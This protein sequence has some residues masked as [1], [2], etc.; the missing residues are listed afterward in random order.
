MQ[1]RDRLIDTEENDSYGEV[2]DGRIEQ[3]RKRIQVGC[4]TKGNVKKYNNF[5]FFNTKCSCPPQ[6]TWFVAI[7]GSD[8]QLWKAIKLR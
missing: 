1:K 2:R 7:L 8:P 6:M 5:F 4:M 3:K